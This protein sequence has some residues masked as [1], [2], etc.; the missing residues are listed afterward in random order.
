MN[1]E[2]YREFDDHRLVSFIQDKKSGLHSFIAIH[3]GGIERPAFGA[4]RFTHYV[5][6]EEALRDV[7]RLSRMMSYKAAMA[8]L[9]YGG[10]KGVIIDTSHDAESRTKLIREYCNRLNYLASH[11]MTGIDVGLFVGDL[12]VMKSCSDQIVGTKVDT[13]GATATGLWYAI[14]TVAES[15][16]GKPDIAGW[17]FAIQGLGKIGSGLLEK[18]YPH[19]GTIYVSDTSA[20]AVA[21]AVKKYPKVN[22][23]AP[24]KIHRQKVDVFSPCAL[25]NSLNERTVPE[26]DCK[27]V[28]GG[29][30]NQ[31]ESPED[32]RKL[33]ARGILYA[34]DYVI[35]AGGMISVADE[36]ENGDVDQGR[37]D[38]KVQIIKKNLVDIIA[39]S[40]KEDRPT[41]IIADEMAEK[42][43]NKLI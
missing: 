6:P 14:Q 8:G 13:T 25:A 29:A 4:T 5:G 31:L 22:P 32:G 38:K 12:P 1:I 40:K 2:R 7:L 42:I 39:K 16:A 18:I 30:N 37:L 24:E 43:F 26:L 28:A 27:I 41:N 20:D 17:S 35:N 15:I 34:P 36:Y 33:Y 9:K 11:F 21:A 3:R 23:V 19:A 10:A